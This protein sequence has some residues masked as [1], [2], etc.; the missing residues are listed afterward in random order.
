MTMIF[1]FLLLIVT[2]LQK[3]ETE[4]VCHSEYHA[5]SHNL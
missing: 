1:R 4:R 3:K 2:A 5:V